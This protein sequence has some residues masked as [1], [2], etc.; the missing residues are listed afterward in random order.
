MGDALGKFEEAEL[1]VISVIGAYLIFRFR[2]RIL[3]LVTGDDRVHADGFDCIW[4]SLFRCCGTCTGD[5][6]RFISCCPCCGVCGL[7]NKNLVDS[8]G[9][10][11]GLLQWEIRVFDV[12]VGDLPVDS[13]AHY[14]VSFEVGEEPPQHTNVSKLTQSKLVQFHGDRILRVRDASLDNSVRV[15]IKEMHTLGSQSISEVFIRPDHLIDWASAP[16]GSTMRLQ[17]KPCSGALSILPCWMLMTCEL[18]KH[19]EDDVVPPCGEASILVTGTNGQ[20]QNFKSVHDLKTVHPLRNAYGIHIREPTEADA[21]RFQRLERLHRCTLKF[22]LCVLLLLGLAGFT[23]K[24]AVTT[25]FEEFERILVL[26]K[27]GVEFPPLARTTSWVLQRCGY[28]KRVTISDHWE[29]LKEDFADWKELLTEHNFQDFQ[30]FLSTTDFQNHPL[31]PVKAKFEDFGSQKR[32]MVVPNS[33]AC[34][35]KRKEVI[36]SCY[37]RPVGARAPNFFNG[38]F[39]CQPWHCR[40]RVLLGPVSFVLAALFFGLL[41]L[42]YCCHRRNLRQMQQMQKKLVEQAH[43]SPGSRDRQDSIHDTDWGCCCSNG[44]Q[45]RAGPFD[46]PVRASTA[47]QPL[48]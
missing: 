46:S 11:S 34:H 47:L 26:H 36:Q 24:L 21:S 8:F 12:V 41:A 45:L 22:W 32:L 38:V 48:E 30:R 31:E 10:W 14:Y 39:R 4:Y 43:L 29:W 28:G 35:P 25:C 9:R 13:P 19:L 6:T 40:F 17:M 1:V 42:M 2:S 33:T 15:V 37:N 44:R 16:G 27:H 23:Y 7:Q 18:S 3:A 20:E 5:W